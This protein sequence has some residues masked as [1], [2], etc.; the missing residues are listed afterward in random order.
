MRELIM[1]KNW[2]IIRTDRVSAPTK[3]ERV[4]KAK[5]AAKV[6]GS[7][8]SKSYEDLKKEGNDAHAAVIA[9]E[10]SILSAKEAN[11]LRSEDLKKEAAAIEKKR[12]SAK[13]KNEKKGKA[14]DKAD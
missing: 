7:V 12:T 1:A 14:M 3:V 4:A 10:N 13:S 5:T 9:R 6:L 11:K 8:K 2:T